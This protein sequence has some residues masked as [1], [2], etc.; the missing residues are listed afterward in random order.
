[1]IN[2][3]ERESFRRGREAGRGEGRAKSHYTTRK[4]GNNFAKII[5]QRAR[6]LNN[7]CHGFCFVVSAPLFSPFPPKSIAKNF[8][9]EQK[10][11]P[12]LVS[13]KVEQHNEIEF[14]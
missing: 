3:D 7:F 2:E 5:Y 12:R 6:N 14:S 11:T 4:I 13:R 8:A 1:M 10:A 9:P